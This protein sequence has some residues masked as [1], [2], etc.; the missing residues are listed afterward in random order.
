MGE[1]A[2]AEGEGPGTQS[3]E[4]TSSVLWSCGLA[5]CPLCNWRLAPR[6]TTLAQEVSVVL[7]REHRGAAA[8]LLSLE[9]KK[10]TKV[11]FCAKIPLLLSLL[12]PLP[13]RG[14][15]LSLLRMEQVVASARVESG[16]F[17]QSFRQLEALLKR[18]QEAPGSALLRRRSGQL[19][20]AGCN[21]HAL[22]CGSRNP[23]SKSDPSP[24][25]A[26]VQT[27]VGIGCC[28]LLGSSRTSLALGIEL[29]S[30]HFA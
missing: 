25:R 24:I 19:R 30:L 22:E 8:E 17:A 12:S 21:F 9:S 10:S 7:S 2:L 1:F 4:W 26:A 15:H 6:D 3:L 13:C 18:A 28:A 5:E 20:R 16:P 29:S 23:Q 11:N 27:E 14:E